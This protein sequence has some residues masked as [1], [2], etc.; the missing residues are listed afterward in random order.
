MNDVERFLVHA[1][2][3]EREAARRYEEL[4]AAMS[5]DGRRDLREFFAGMAHFSRLHL[6]DAQARGGF[7]DLP[8]LAPHEFEWP[9]GVAPRRPNGRVSTR[10]WIRSTRSGWRSPRS[11]AAMPIT[12]PWP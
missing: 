4:A 5:T 10:R 7:R 8:S 11:S 12:P 2:A 1:I 3:L 9:D 6:R